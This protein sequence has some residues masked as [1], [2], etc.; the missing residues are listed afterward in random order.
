M[1]DDKSKFD[2]SFV[3]PPWDVVEVVSEDS[4]QEPRKFELEAD[5]NPVP[6][7]VDHPHVSVKGKLN[8]FFRHWQSLCA[9]QFILSVI[10]CGYKIQ[11]IFTP[12][13]RGITR[14]FRQLSM[15]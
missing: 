8:S 1:V 13:S 3:N 15:K 11:F 14:T 10:R 7:S 6:S 2:I 5:L 12:P 9:P 4:V